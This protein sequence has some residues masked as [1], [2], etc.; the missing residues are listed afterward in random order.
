MEEFQQ[1]V[2]RVAGEGALRLYIF[3]VVP[4]LDATHFWASRH[5][6]GHPQDVLMEQTDVRT[7]DGFF[8]HLTVV[9]CVFFTGMLKDTVTKVHCMREPVV[10]Y[11]LC[12][13]HIDS[14]CV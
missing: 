3:A 12:N 13:H 2:M 6:E 8:H 1:H 5:P 10:Q 11:V 9:G 4:R 7:S 14:Y